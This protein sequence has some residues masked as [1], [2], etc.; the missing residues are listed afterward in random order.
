MTNISIMRSYGMT[1][2]S[3]MFSRIKR[4][5]ASTLTFRSPKSGLIKLHRNASEAFY[6]G[7]EEH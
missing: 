5:L 3:K 2:I 7:N 6:D 4:I 1:N